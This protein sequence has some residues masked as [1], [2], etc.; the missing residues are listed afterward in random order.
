MATDP[1]KLEEVLADLPADGIRLTGGLALRLTTGN[2]IHVLG[3]S[4]VRVAPSAQE[5]EIIGRAILQIHRPA[6][7]MRGRRPLPIVDRHGTTH[8]IWRFYWPAEPVELIHQSP[9]Q[10]RI[11]L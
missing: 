5:M 11:E 7:L 1:P 9:E 6:V 8:V 2:G 4:R 10:M 3:C